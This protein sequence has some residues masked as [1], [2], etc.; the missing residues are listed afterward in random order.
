MLGLG[1][2]ATQADVEAKYNQLCEALAPSK[3]ADNAW[4]ETQAR[5]AMAKISEAYNKLRDPDFKKRYEKERNNEGAVDGALKDCRP[6]LGQICVASGLI[7]MEQLKE[8]VEEQVK[9]GLPLGEVLQDKQYL[10]PIQ[11]EGLLMGQEMIDVPSQCTDPA[12]K[13]LIALDVVSEDMV[14]IAQMEQKSLGQPI[15]SLL[16]RRGWVDA[17]I[18]KALGLADTE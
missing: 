16:L 12:G 18:L 5:K 10:S 9:T 14:L 7:S 11:L 13:R 3:F 6:R 17:G 1:D 2:D 8:A 15:T 4:A